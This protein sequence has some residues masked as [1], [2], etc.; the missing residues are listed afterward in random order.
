VEKVIS[1]MIYPDAG[2]TGLALFSDEK[3]IVKTLK[4][5]DLSRKLN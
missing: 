5:W 3:A 1:T 4:I 2:A